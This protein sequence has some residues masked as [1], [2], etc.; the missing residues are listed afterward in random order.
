MREQAANLDDGKLV[1]L[2]LNGDGDA[3][4]VLVRRYQKL[5]YNVL[6]EMVRNHDTAADLTQDT[7]L[8]AFRG[9]A[10]FR[11]EAP[12]KPWLLRIATNCGLNWIRDSKIDDSLE[13]ILEENPAA[14]PAGRQNVEAEVARRMSQAQL[15]QA[16]A[17]L[18]VRYRHVFVLRN[19]HDLS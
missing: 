6:Y 8:K 5:V 10:R 13:E 19:Q 14:E 18:P 7:F 3:Y 17:E 2:A 11:Q 9:L 4:E 12:F 16:L 1:S 15:S